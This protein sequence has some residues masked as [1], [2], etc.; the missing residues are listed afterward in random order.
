L[1]TENLH[2][3]YFSPIRWSYQREYGGRDM[4]HAW[5]NDKYI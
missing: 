4:Q 1:H 5:K 2:N 3:L